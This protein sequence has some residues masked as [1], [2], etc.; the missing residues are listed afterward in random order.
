MCLSHDENCVIFG[1]LNSRCGTG[2]RSLVHSSDLTYS[3]VDSI[4]KPNANRKSLLQLCT[5]CDLLIANN[6][7][8]PKVTLTGALTFRQKVTWISEL[9]LMLMSRSIVD[10][11]TSISVDQ[12][13]HFPSDP[14]PITFTVDTSFRLHTSMDSLY[15]RAADVGQHAV[16]LTKA[17]S[18]SRKAVPIKSINTQAFIQQLSSIDIPEVKEGCDPEYFASYFS[19]SIY[20][21]GEKPYYTNWI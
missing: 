20:K 7:S 2:V 19:D 21:H 5:D 17:K 11:I 14:A 9:D 18:L 3:P 8:T 6:L 16:C 13:L 12:N 15:L 4:I 1:D 10:S